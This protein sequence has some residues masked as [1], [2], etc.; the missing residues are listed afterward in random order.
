MAR[1]GGSDEPTVL[2]P[3]AEFQELV[4]ASRRNV[5]LAY[6]GGAVAVAAALLLAVSEGGVVL[7]VGIFAIVGAALLTWGVRESRSLV[8][9]YGPVG[10]AKQASPFETFDGV[11]GNREHLAAT[12]FVDPGERQRNR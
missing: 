4:R 11:E 3:R 9:R 12:P 10:R 2:V 6:A 1:H 5:T 7:W 8:R